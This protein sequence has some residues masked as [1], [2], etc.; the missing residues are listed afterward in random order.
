M[1]DC[2]EVAVIVPTRALAERAPLIQRA[3]TSILSQEGVRPTPIVVVNGPDWD[4]V[5]VREFDVNPRVRLI[6]LD[7]PG[8][9]GALQAGRA[10][11]SAEWFSALD[12]DDIYLPGALAMRVKTLRNNPD[13]DTVVTNG[14]RRDA[15]GEKVHIS[16]ISAVEKN[17]LQ[18]LTRGNWLLPGAW[19]CRSENIGGWLFEGMPKFRECTF[20]AIQFALHGH[21]RF[22]AE[23][24]VAWY[25]DTPASESK[26]RDYILGHELALERMLELPVP[27][28]FAQSLRKKITDARHGEAALHL[29][30]G[31]LAQSWRSHLRSLSGPRGWRYAPFSLRLL[32]ASF[33]R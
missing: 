1:S 19:L 28:E 21:L 23:P 2:P 5:L 30:E 22:L 17:P 10:A 16:Q 31:N 9:P 6:K 14:L 8:I 33:R 32:L 24:T 7:T 26:T 4:P 3:L 18:S 13:C 12:D 25:T 29:R 20:L 27:V 11:V 15:E